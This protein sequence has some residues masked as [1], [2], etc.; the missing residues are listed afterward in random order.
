MNAI[1]RGSRARQRELYEYELPI[2]QQSALLANQNRDSKRKAEPY[3]AEDFSMFKPLEAVNAPSSVYGSA[4]MTM[5]K[6]GTYPSW[7]LFCFKELSAI[8]D[9]DYVPTLPALVSENAILLHPSKTAVGYRGMLIARE[10]ASDQLTSFSFPD[11]ST[12]LLTVPPVM[13]K[14]IAEEGVTLYR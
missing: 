14:I 2:A 3:K 1:A 6:A 5:V 7:A 12:V 10:A 13:T 9:A 11:G 8:A 4:A